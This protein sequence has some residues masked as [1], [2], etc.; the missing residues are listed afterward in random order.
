MNCSYF[1]VDQLGLCPVYERTLTQ[2]VFRAK[3]TTVAADVIELLIR[4]LEAK[5]YGSWS[6][7]S[8]E[9]HSWNG[10]VIFAEYASAPN[11]GTPLVLHETSNLQYNFDDFS[12]NKICS[13]SEVS[14]RGHTQSNLAIRTMIHMGAVGQLCYVL[15][16]T[17]AGHAK[18]FSSSRQAITQRVMAS[19]KR[20]KF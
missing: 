13:P 10:C 1:P 9:W 15:C 8:Q 6:Q 19:A 2:T 4:K 17:R 20:D 7:R 11:I 12:N 5:N 3:T 18:Q 14:G 16:F